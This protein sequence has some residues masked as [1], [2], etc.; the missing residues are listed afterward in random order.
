MTTIGNKKTEI[1]GVQALLA[2]AGKDFQKTTKLVFGGTT[3]TL[4]Q[5]LQLLQGFLDLMAAVDTARATFQA[6]LKAFRDQAPITRAQIR[7]FVVFVRATF[8][9][10]P[11]VLADFGLAPHKVPA[12]KTVKTKT[13]AVQKALATRTARHTMGKVQKAAITGTP[14]ATAPAVT[15]TPATPAPPAATPPAVPAPQTTTPPAEPP[16]VAPTPKA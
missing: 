4:T 15:T 5:V 2:G 1:A 14:A 3:F 10:N 13:V 7:A 12:P 9:N 6:K 8:G 16:P 11:D